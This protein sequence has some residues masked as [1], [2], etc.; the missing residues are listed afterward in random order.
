MPKVH[1]SEWIHPLLAQRWSPVIFDA[2]RTVV[3]EDMQALLEAARWA[4]SCFN[5]Q[6]WRFIVGSKAQSPQVWQKIHDCLAEGNQG[7]TQAAPVLMLG[8]VMT[9]FEHN[10][11]P[12]GHAVYDLGTAAAHLTVEASARDL[13]VHQMAGFSADK[14]AELFQLGDGLQAITALAVGYHGDPADADPALRE[15]EARPRERKALKDL[16][17]AGE[18]LLA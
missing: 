11:K 4:P 12:N 17:L 16:L 10:G 14:A 15:R 13:L 7:W 2:Q 6:P 9:H 1:N 5:A 8:V 3:S 18:D